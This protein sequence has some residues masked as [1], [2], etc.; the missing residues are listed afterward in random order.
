MT[1]KEL[2]DAL[3]QVDPNLP[4]YFGKDEN[5]AEE[6][7]VVTNLNP[8]GEKDSYVLITTINE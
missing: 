1:V 8:K 5:L 3:K 2:T 7:A 4:V 6:I